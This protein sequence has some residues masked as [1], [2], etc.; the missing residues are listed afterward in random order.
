[1]NNI[2][3]IEQY[4]RNNSSPEIRALIDEYH[5]FVKL[6]RVGLKASGYV[7]SKLQT[8]V[9]NKALSVPVE[10]VNIKN[11]GAHSVSFTFDTKST[12]EDFSPSDFRNNFRDIYTDDF[13]I[14]VSVSIVEVMAA[15]VRTT[16]LTLKLYNAEPKQKPILVIKMPVYAMRSM[17]KNM[18]LKPVIQSAV[19]EYH[20]WYKRNPFIVIDES[21]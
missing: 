12:G 15:N 13:Q 2:E 9:I 10:S 4:E 5:H 8:A 7:L 18:L 20:E 3:L 21:N 19:I 11:G 17:I 1:M 16:T 6:E 14:C